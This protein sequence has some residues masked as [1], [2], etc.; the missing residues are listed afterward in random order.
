MKSSQVR[1]KFFNFF[2]SKG[3]KQI[4]SASIL[5]NYDENLMFTNSGMNQFRNIFLGTQEPNNLRVVNSQK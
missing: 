2:R 4:P 3:H 5:N 1:Q